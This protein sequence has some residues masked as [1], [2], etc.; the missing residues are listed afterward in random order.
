M[1]S[2]NVLTCLFS[3]IFLIL[4]LN[5]LYIGKNLLNTLLIVECWWITVYFLLSFV[6]TFTGVH[7]AGL[8]L[9][10]IIVFAGLEVVLGFYFLYFL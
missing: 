9:P 8:V 2:W 7:F 6:I 3:V 4:C 5:F 10:L 1:H